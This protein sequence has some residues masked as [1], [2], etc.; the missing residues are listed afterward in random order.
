MTTGYGE[1]TMTDELM[2][3]GSAEDRRS[4]LNAL[5]CAFVQGAKWWEHHSTGFTMWQSDQ[6]VALKEAERR[7]E[8]GSLGKPSA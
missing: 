7:L 3:A 4:E 8:N 1:T 2:S 6:G 5:L